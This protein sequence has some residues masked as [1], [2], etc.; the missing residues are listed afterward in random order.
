M[1]T[2]NGTYKPQSAYD[3]LHALVEKIPQTQLLI[4][5]FMLA[6]LIGGLDYLTGDKLSF[7]VFYLIP[8]ITV[9]WY[10]GIYQGVVLSLICII[11]WAFADVLSRKEPLPIFIVVWNAQIRLAFFLIIANLLKKLQLSLKHQTQLARVDYLTKVANSRY[12]YEII[13]MEFNRTTRYKRVFSVVY[14]DIDDFKKINDDFGH[15]KGDEVLRLVAN[16]LE[17]ST[18]NTDTVS[19]I[20][21]DEFIILMPETDY[22]QAETALE[23]IKKSLTDNMHAERWSVTFSIGA[24]TYMDLPA[25][26]D[27]IINIADTCMYEVKKAGKNMVM[28]KIFGSGSD[29]KNTR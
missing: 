4:F 12:F 9:T 19:R 16:T 15:K 22:E 21:G 18:R 10:A 8:I 24:I 11:I 27:A 14:I 29:I 1:K 2:D 3:Y 28:H 26:P 23:R 5:C 13:E 20:A 7:S 25:S 17:H 6:L